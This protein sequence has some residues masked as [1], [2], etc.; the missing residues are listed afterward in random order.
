MKNPLAIMAALAAGFSGI[1]K[2]EK[3]FGYS[4]APQLN[5]RRKIRHK[6]TIHTELSVGASYN[7]SMYRL[8]LRS[9]KPD[10]AKP[11]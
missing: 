5:S 4:R 8:F 10:W 11:I 3:M 1:L 7:K 6:K 9:R 2:G